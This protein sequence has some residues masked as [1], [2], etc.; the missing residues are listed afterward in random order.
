M[1]RIA[2][3]AQLPTDVDL[4]FASIQDHANISVATTSRL[5]ASLI[6]LSSEVGK[7]LAGFLQSPAFN[8]ES[9]PSDLAGVFRSLVEASA[10]A[11]VSL[12]VAAEK[13]LKKV[14]DRWPK[15][16]EYPILFDEAHNQYEQIPRRIEISISERRVGDRTYVYQQCNGVNIGDRITD[17]KEEEDDYRFHD[18]FHLAY[19][20][21]LGWSPVTR[22]LFKVKRK[23][24]AKIDENEDGARAI[25]TEEAISAW[26]FHHAVQLSYFQSLK[27]LDY[28]LLKAVR[29]L[30]KGYEVQKCPL[31]LWEEAILQGYAVF[32]ELRSRRRGVVI[33]DLTTRKLEFREITNDSI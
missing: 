13:N 6:K 33:A 22:A 2:F 9:V 5:E 28:G 11:Q 24:V 3:P 31:W 16:R 29:S 26:I 32:R 25:I 23:S 1:A 7:L 30:S 12:A 17:N 20:A 15:K 27:T 8:H 18:V 19:A 10:E 21:V 4:T 14:F